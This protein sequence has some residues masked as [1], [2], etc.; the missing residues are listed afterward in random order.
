[1][2]AQQPLTETVDETLHASAE[3]IRTSRELLEELDQRLARSAELLDQD[4][5]VVDLRDTGA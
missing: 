1:M 2:D 3:R 5:S 4:P